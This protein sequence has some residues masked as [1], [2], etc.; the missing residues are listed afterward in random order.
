LIAAV[1]L[2]VC[3]CGG[4]YSG[5]PADTPAGQLEYARHLLERG[6]YYDAISEL[7][8]FTSENP[9]SGL[10]D[11]ALFYLGEAYLGRRNYPMAAA[12]FERLLREFPGSGHAPAARYSLGV[13]Y[14]EQSLSA[15]LDPTM[16]ERAIEQFLLF[17]RLHPESQH[18]P[19][20]RERVN[21]LR[22]KLA[23]KTYLNG[24]LYM[25]LKQP[26]SA[27]FYFDIVITEYPESPFAPKSLFELAKAYE[28]EG[29]ETAAIGRYN[30]LLR[31]HPQAEEAPLARARLIELGAG[32]PEPDAG[33]AGDVSDDQSP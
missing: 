3:G 18:V 15:E 22:G 30:E 13:A 8:L 4:Q 14:D 16:T 7:T 24:R 25:K 10:L 1:C 19:E 31:I 5:P 33:D 23:K 9:G 2:L 12:E 27:R 28:M 11:T 17:M 20:A 26:E 32:S 6:A 29:N 21:S